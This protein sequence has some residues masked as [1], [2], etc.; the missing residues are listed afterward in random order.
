MLDLA[1][2]LDFLGYWSRP[3]AERFAERIQLR[4]A[5]LGLHPDRGRRVPEDSTNALRELFVG[6]YR[7][8]YRVESRVVWIV[9]FIHGS[10]DLRP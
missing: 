7:L 4:A 1:E 9:A 6:P 5:S 8:M 10:R 3:A 2:A